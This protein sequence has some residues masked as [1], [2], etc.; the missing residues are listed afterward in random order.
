LD[1]DNLS[2]STSN[3]WKV[4][5]V[6][7]TPDFIT[8]AVS[9]KWRTKDNLPTPESIFKKF[10]S[11]SDIKKIT[12]DIKNLDVWDSGL[13]SFIIKL[14]KI[15]KAQSI[16]VCTNGL[17]K[18]MLSLLTLAKAVPKRKIEKKLQPNSLLQRLGHA[19]I[20]F[21]NS[22]EDML[23]FIGLIA[24][25]FSKIFRRKVGF[26]REDLLYLI[27]DCSVNSL[28]I[29]LLISFLIGLILAFIGAVQLQS[30]G[31]GIYVANLV[32][33]GVTRE[34]S[35]LMIAIIMTGR[36]GASYAAQLG[37]MQ[38]NEEIDALKTTVISP[39]DFLVM[40]RILALTMMVPLLCLF[41]DVFGM[42]GGMI[43][44]IKVL[45][46]SFNQ[47]L[48]QTMSA[49]TTVDII[50]GLVKSIFFGL[51]VAIAGCYQGLNCGRNSD[52]VGRA[53]TKAVVSG[54]LAI[55][56]ADAFFEIILNTLKI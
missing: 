35:P 10:P 28:P 51:L 32:A 19:S 41:G 3:P 52:A 9:G 15:C 53:T 13:L 5:F 36:T 34:M 20:E 43:V 6:G 2:A 21:Y 18:N 47:Y 31:A 44:S 39:I 56:I 29:I 48:V 33:V 54:I 42:L 11:S 45:H 12:Y 46:I 26:L 23:G 1:L 8:I 4:G 38:V 55:I 16:E 24:I 7:S 50:V 40:P 30:F 17:T 14:N 25:S 27:Q 37:S 22:I 49:I